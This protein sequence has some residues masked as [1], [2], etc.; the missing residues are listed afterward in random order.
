[1]RVT[2]VEQL[3]EGKGHLGRTEETIMEA[4]NVVIATGLFQRLKLPFFSADLPIQITQL[5]SGD[6]R[7]PQSLPPGA[8]LVVWSA[9]SGRQIAEGLY[10]SGRRVYL[11]IGS[12]GRVPLRYRGKDIYE[13]LHM[14]AFELLQ[15]KITK[16]RLFRPRREHYSHD[17]MHIPSTMKLRRKWEIGIRDLRNFFDV[18]RRL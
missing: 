5:H 1:M 16:L 12:A 7:N 8:V 18:E 10:Q 11:C 4:R 3:A 2:S 15:G 17:L 6:C 14:R 9:Q 13:W